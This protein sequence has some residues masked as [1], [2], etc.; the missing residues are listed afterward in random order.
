MTFDQAEI[1]LRVI[2]ERAMR[3]QPQQPLGHAFFWAVFRPEGKVRWTRRIILSTD[4]RQ[5]L[6]QIRKDIEAEANQPDSGI[7]LRSLYYNLD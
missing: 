6:D 7:E 2:A 3:K 1:K 4:G 5:N